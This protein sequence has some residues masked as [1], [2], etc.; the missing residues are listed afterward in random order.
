MIRVSTHVFN[1][2]DDLERLA[3]GVRGMLVTWQFF[4][5]R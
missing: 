1:S 5:K 3:A 2:E 4:L